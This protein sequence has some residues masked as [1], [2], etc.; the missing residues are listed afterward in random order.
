MY[1][2]RYVSRWQAGGS[3]P[4]A[5]LLHERQQLGHKDGASL[6]RVNIISMTINNINIAVYRYHH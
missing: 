5:L 2:P 6:Q 1:I 3:S 4:V